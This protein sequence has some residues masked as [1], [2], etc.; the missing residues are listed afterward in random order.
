MAHVLLF[1]SMRPMKVTTHRNRE[2]KHA[3]D[4]SHKVAVCRHCLAQRLR[5]LMLQV[6]D[7][8][9]LENSRTTLGNGL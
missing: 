5:D 3:Y 2:L 8:A 9:L 7:V 1:K 4:P 6:I